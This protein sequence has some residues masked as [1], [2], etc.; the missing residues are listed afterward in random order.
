MP[1]IGRT[2]RSNGK[3]RDFILGD[4]ICIAA[5]FAVIAQL[6]E[7]T[8]DAAAVAAHAFRK[9]RRFIESLRSFQS[10]YIKVR[11]PKQ[12]PQLADTFTT[13]ASQNVRVAYYGNGIMLKSSRLFIAHFLTLLLLAPSLFAV[14]THHPQPSVSAPTGPPSL[15]QVR[16]ITKKLQSWYDPQ[17]GLWKTTGWWNSANALTVL[18][19]FSKVTHDSTY[20]SVIAHTYAVNIHSGFLGHY[21]DDEGWWALA[22]I[23][24][25]DL[26][27]Q[28][29]YLHTAQ[30]IFTNMTT[31]WDNTCGGGLW[32]SK[33]RAYKNAIANELFLSVAAHLSNLAPTATERAHYAAWA[34]REWHWFH[35]SGMIESDHLISDGLTSAC[36]DNHKTKWSY[37]Q[38]VILGGLVELY[39]HDHHRSHLREA[40]RIANAAIRKL[41]GT[42]GILHEPC[43][44]NCG[45]DG[46]QFKG[47]FMRNLALLYRYRHKQRYR[48][49]ILRNATSILRYDQSPSH[50]LGLVWSGPP[51]V[52][53]AS[54]QSSAM[55]ALVA[56][57]QVDTKEHR[58]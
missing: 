13:P 56:A 37:N 39:R 54:T 11:L 43:E 50:G 27:G 25:Y 7:D 35:H 28:Q 5:G 32:W 18:I 26:T 15:L 4:A 17:T 3:L 6:R 24:S 52:A 53:N 9:S 44:P 55:D 57:L 19:N 49:F 45:A 42:H 30:N 33:K 12:F 46:S 36:K 22:W 1:I 47:I 14:T 41:S 48:R 21:Y 8:A 40:A 38:G 16:R 20:D 51:G 2:S 31:G 34:K 58:Q 10:T 29:K 23:D